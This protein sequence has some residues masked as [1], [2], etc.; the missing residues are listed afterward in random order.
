MVARVVLLSGSNRIL[1]TPIARHFGINEI[2]CTEME[3]INGC[4]T[5]Q[6]IGDLCIREGKLKKAQNYCMKN[7]ILPDQVGFYGDS[8]SDLQIFNWVKWPNV[9]NPN[10]KLR[11]IAEKRQWE[12]VNW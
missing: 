3:V 4:Y 10:D 5:G 12:I 11:A 9:V 2:V 8:L 1:V 6:I 7:S